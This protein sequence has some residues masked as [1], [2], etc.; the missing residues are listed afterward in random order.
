M[1]LFYSFTCRDENES[2]TQVGYRIWIVKKHKFSDTDTNS[3]VHETKRVLLGWCTS[4]YESDTESSV[5]GNYPNPSGRIRIPN[6]RVPGLTYSMGLPISHDWPIT[7]IWAGWKTP[8]QTS[9]QT[10]C[11]HASIRCL[12]ASQGHVQPQGARVRVLGTPRSDSHHAT[13]KHSNGG[14]AASSSAQHLAGSPIPCR[15]TLPGPQHSKQFTGAGAAS[16]QASL[17][18]LVRDSP[19]YHLGP[20]RSADLNYRYRLLLPVAID[21]QHSS[22]QN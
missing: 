2:G 11:R 1:Y 18:P 22:V 4:G 10:Q 7:I 3:F 17:H 5:S 8:N 6:P 12:P 14:G 19:R 15:P 21:V 13:A 16:S 9:L 20:R